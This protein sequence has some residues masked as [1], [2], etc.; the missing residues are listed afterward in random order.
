MTNE[1]R[2]ERQLPAIL[3]DLYLGPSPDY[4]DEVLAAAVRTRQRPAWTFPGRWLPMDITTRTIPVTRLP[5]R[6][7][8]ILAL[9]AL[10]LAV[11][12]AVAVGS[13]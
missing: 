10:L 8:G 3:E 9:I 7:L 6:Q 11:A 1:L 13:Q 5:W 12:L 2:F 4:R